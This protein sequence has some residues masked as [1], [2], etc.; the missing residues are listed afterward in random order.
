MVGVPASAATALPWKQLEATMLH[1][2]KQFKE[3]PFS[4]L[5]LSVLFA[6]SC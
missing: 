4:S 3:Q 1:G 2:G 5:A 6:G